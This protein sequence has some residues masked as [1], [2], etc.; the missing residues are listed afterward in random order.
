MALVGLVIAVLGTVPVFPKPAD[1][2]GV[3]IIVMI[4]ILVAGIGLSVMAAGLV[5]AA[6]TG[7]VRVGH[8]IIL[9]GLLVV[10][11]GMAQMMFGMALLTEF[12]EALAAGFGWVLGKNHNPYPFGNPLLMLLAQVAG[13]IIAGVGLV[14][15]RNKQPVGLIQHPPGSGRPET[16]HSDETNSVT[17]GGR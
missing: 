9:I 1:G 6:R 11:L 10:A 8:I 15:S 4:C 3:S 2:D 7:V 16:R 13:G 5:T 12:G 17:A 14:M